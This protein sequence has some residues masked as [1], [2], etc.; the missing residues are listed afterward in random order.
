MRLPAAGDVLPDPA[1]EDGADDPVQAH[2]FRLRAPGRVGRNGFAGR[3]DAQLARRER[4][5]ALC[6]RSAE[7]FEFG[8][9]RVGRNE[10]PPALPGT[11]PEGE[12][13][14]LRALIENH[15]RLPFGAAAGQHADSALRSGADTGILRQVRQRFGRMADD[16]IPGGGESGDRP[17]LFRQHRLSRDDQEFFRGGGGEVVYSG[18]APEHERVVQLLLQRF[19]H[20]VEGGSRRFV[21]KRFRAVENPDLRFD[22]AGVVI[23]GPRPMGGQRGEGVP[24]RVPRGELGGAADLRLPP[25]AVRERHRQ[26]AVDAAHKLGV[27]GPVHG[28]SGHTVAVDVEAF[29]ERLLPVVA[30]G[31]R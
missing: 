30:D 5:F 26:Q 15:Q 8:V 25:V 7:R 21:G 20:G 14:P 13:L 2:R 4:E 11:R 3:Q 16:R 19:K 24:D 6:F 22:R 29:G 12:E 28:L 27:S 9:N 23:S 18:E 1:A 10:L 17:A 31:R